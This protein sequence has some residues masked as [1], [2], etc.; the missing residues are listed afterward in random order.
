MKKQLLI[1]A[2]LFS[3]SG[4]FAQTKLTKEEIKKDS[5]IKADIITPAVSAAQGQTPDWNALTVDITKKYDATYA[6]RTVTKAIIY[7][8]YYKDWPAFTAAIV[9]YTEK[10]ESH[11]NLKLLNTNANYI[12]KYSDEKKELE[13][14]LA[15]SKHTVEK[16]PENAAYKTTYA[17][18]QEKLATK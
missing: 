16:D 2:L 4:L 8:S 12:L 10:Y 6:D 18:L 7:F 14:A 1:V 17:G 13:A 15:W 9:K 5:V 11:D 3:T